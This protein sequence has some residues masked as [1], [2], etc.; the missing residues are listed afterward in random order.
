M[1]A[2]EHAWT[3][4]D[5][6][7]LRYTNKKERRKN[8]NNKNKSKNKNKKNKKKK[9]KKNMM[10]KKKRTKVVMTVIIAHTPKT[11]K[12]TYWPLIP[13]ATSP[14]K[15]PP[16]SGCGS[17]RRSVPDPGAGGDVLESDNLK[18]A[19][20]KAPRQGEIVLRWP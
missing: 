9:K 4:L 13:T 20:V 19:I 5:S 8:R 16:A 2:S 14:R 3:D 12:G 17:P 10:M 6:R 11:G 1:K 18:Q 15:L 7:R